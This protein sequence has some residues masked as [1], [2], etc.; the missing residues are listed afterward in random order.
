[1]SLVNRYHWR[2]S[3]HKMPEFTGSRAH[4]DNENHRFGILGALTGDVCNQGRKSSFLFTI[5]KE[6]SREGPKSVPYP[7]L[8]NSKSV[9]F[10]PLQYPHEEKIEKKIS[11]FFEIFFRNFFWSPVSRTV[12]KNVK[13]GPLGVFE[14]PFF[15]K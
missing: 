4:N 14:H 10:S 6:A 8:K 2:A 12:P 9:K 13:R 5:P 7:R 11:I 3:A 1:M 15:C